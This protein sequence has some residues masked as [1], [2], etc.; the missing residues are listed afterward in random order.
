[1]PKK[2]FIL[3]VSLCLLCACG[4]NSRDLQLDDVP[5]ITVIFYDNGLGDLGYC[6]NIFYGLCR[7][8]EEYSHDHKIRMEFLT[9]KESDISEKTVEDWFNKEKTSKELL[10]LTSSKALGAFRKHPEWVSKPG[11]EVLLMDCNDIQTDVYTRYVPLYGVSYFTG[12]AIKEVGLDKAATLIANR[13]DKPV[14]EGAQGFADGF[15][16]AG[17]KLEDEDTFFLGESSGS[18]YDLPDKAEQLAY[19][20]SRDSYRFLFPICGG[21]ALGVFRYARRYESDYGSENVPFYSCGMDVD[22]QTMSSCILFSIIK[23]YDRILED[24]IRNWLEG[25]HL[26]YH[27]DLLLDTGYADVVIA[28][29]YTDRIGE[30]EYNR[31][32]V[33]AIKA[34]REY[35]SK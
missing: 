9:P 25:N 1:M 21:S 8:Y 32:K 22:Q 12:I 5:V 23:R 15:R 18:G 16:F 20:L 33:A 6:D 29:G 28:G 14:L 27:Q 17:G 24:F 10:I 19:N 35:Y 2:I 26:E 7:I 4:D 30:E 3:A 13:E 11:A 31:M 34:E